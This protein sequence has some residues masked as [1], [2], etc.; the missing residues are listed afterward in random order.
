MSRRAPSFQPFLTGAQ[1]K[2]RVTIVCTIGPACANVKTLCAMAEAGMEVVRLNF[3]HGDLAQKTEMIRLVREAERKLGQPLSILQDLQ[4]PKLRVGEF[5]GGGSAEIKTGSTLVL[6]SEPCACTAGRVYV[7]YRQLA[8]DIRPGD[9][10]LLA[11][12]SITLRAAAVKGG[13]VM[14]DVIHGG[15]LSSRKGVNL[16]GVRL[17]IP[18]LT[19]KDVRDVRFGCAHGVDWIA[20]SFVREAGDIGRLRALVAREAKGRRCTRGGPYLRSI[21]QPT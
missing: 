17:S 9:A 21:S 14:C 4:G 6:T 8:K 1:F 2:R 5:P 7:N 18:A 13:D 3:S 20:L 19:A 11:D 15:M 12:G 16:P 10:V